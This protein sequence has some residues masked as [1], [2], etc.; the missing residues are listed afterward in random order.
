MIP[1]IGPLLEAL[2][3]AAGA[4]SSVFGWA[5]KK[6]ELNNTPEMKAAEEA[7]KAQAE[8]ERIAADLQDKDDD[9]SRADIN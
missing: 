7:K 3:K 6:Q 5:E 8:R 4:V 1:I 9:K 2:G